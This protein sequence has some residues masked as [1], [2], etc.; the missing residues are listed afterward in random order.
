MNDHLKKTKVGIFWSFLN[1]GGSQI[2]SLIVTFILARLIT[3]AEFGLIGMIAV[4]TGFAKI[5]VDFGFSTALIQKAEINQRDINTVFSFNLF[6]G[7]MLS[8]LFFSLSFLIADFYEEPLLEKI[9]KIYAPLFFISAIGGVNRALI[10][11]S[12]KFKLST[13]ISMVTT[14]ISALVAITMGLYGFGVWSILSQIIVEQV[15]STSLVLI[16]YPVNQKPR[17]YKSSFKGLSKNGFNM[18]GNSI[19]NY[20]SRNADNLIIGKMLGD[21]ALGIYTKSYGIMMLPLRNISRV[22]GK[23][24]FPSFSILQNDIL[25][26]RMIYLKATRIIAYVTF[27]IM[28]GLAILSEPFVLITFGPQWKDMIPI[29]SILSGIGALQSVFTLNGVIYNSLGKAHI[30]FRISIVRSIMNIAAFIIGVKFGGLIGLTIAYTIVTILGFVPSF[31]FAGKQIKV[32]ILDMAKN[33]S[34]ALIST[35]FTA[36]IVYLVYIL[37]LSSEIG[38]VLKLVIP[39]LTGSLIYFSIGYLMGFDELSFIKQ[40]LFKKKNKQTKT[41][42]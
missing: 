3:P 38:V 25:Q 8:I 18:A 35:L 4:F 6:S 12:L 17:F 40:N 36:V 14:I 24:V 2:V 11:K 22:I 37:I 10:V 15:L 30:A 31:Y 9:T 33:L 29:V 21:G 27:P 16:L 41:R 7:G 23:V 19:I 28:A 39:A 1:Q 32:S 13:I 20:W 5:F 42:N 34:H 26:I